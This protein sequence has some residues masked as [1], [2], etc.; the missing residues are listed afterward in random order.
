MKKLFV[1][2]LII[3]SGQNVWALESEI[4]TRLQTAEMASIISNHGIDTQLSYEIAKDIIKQQKEIEEKAEKM[5][6]AEAQASL[7]D[8]ISR[9]KNSSN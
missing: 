2:L 1:T 5:S 8:I 9:L 6:A 3:F 7:E 4:I